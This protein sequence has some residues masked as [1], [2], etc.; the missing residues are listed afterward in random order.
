[1]FGNLLLI[2]VVILIMW[3]GILAYYMITSRQQNDLQKDIENLREM[4][5][6]KKNHS[7]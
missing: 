4:L 5:D 2:A 6:E 7:S 3:V 1:M